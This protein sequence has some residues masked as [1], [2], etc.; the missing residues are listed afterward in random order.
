MLEA[1]LFE[2]TLNYN[3]KQDDNDGFEEQDPVSLT[4]IIFIYMIILVW[5]I[6]RALKCSQKTPDS[7]AIHLFFCFVSPS[8]YLLCSYTVPDFCSQ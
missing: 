8:L 6:T 4:I 5:G 1:K 7:R 3:K 2:N